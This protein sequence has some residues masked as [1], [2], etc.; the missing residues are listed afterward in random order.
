MAT[1]GVVSRIATG[2]CTAYDIRDQPVWQQVR[3][4]AVIPAHRL[5]RDA[6][7]KPPA[8]SCKIK[9]GAQVPCLLGLRLEG[10]EAHLVV[11]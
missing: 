5:P 11:R 2:S 7:P 1:S 3:S 8:L 9:Y 4:T 6:A 10:F